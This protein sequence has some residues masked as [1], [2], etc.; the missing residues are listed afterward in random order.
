MSRNLQSQIL[1]IFNF[2]ML[3]KKYKLCVKTFLQLVCE[4]GEEEADKEFSTGFGPGHKK[5]CCLEV[6]Q[7]AVHEGNT[8]QA[9]TA[10]PQVWQ[11]GEKCASWRCKLDMEEHT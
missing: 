2:Y 11:Q 6:C 8:H 4:R 10:V 9:D 5:E 1:A 3:I 7:G